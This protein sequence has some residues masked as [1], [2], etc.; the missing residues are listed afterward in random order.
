MDLSEPAQISQAVCTAGHQETCRPH[1]GHTTGRRRTRSHPGPPF[2]SPAPG[3]GGSVGF[4]PPQGGVAHRRRWG[5]QGTQ[6]R[7]PSCVRRW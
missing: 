5:G 1:R 3:R 7:R 4:H 6:A 2:R